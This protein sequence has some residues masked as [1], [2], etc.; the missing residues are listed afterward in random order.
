MSEK[1]T[2]ATETVEIDP[3]MSVMPEEPGLMDVPT[4]IP[5]LDSMLAEMSFALPAYQATAWKNKPSTETPIDAAAMTR[6]EQRLVDL[7]NAVNGLRDS[8]SRTKYLKK[9][10]AKTLEIEMS[11][12]SFAICLCGNSVITIWRSTY[13]VFLSDMPTG[14]TSEKTSTGVRLTRTTGETGWLAIV[15]R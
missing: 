5:E 13:D 3:G 15:Y 11:A 10:W 6:I 14:V 2:K 12:D 1:N 8:V 9:T 4:V 7:T